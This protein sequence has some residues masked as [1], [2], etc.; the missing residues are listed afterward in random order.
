LSISKKA[1]EIAIKSYE[2]TQKRYILGK[3][4]ITDLNISLEEKDRAIL[5]YLNSLSRF[6]SD[7]YTLRRLTLYDFIL[8]K[9]ITTEDIIFN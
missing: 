2:I 8:N 6:W 9:R 4:Q 1:Q 7:Y 5:N 3:I